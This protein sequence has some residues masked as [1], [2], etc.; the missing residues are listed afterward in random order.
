[1]NKTRVYYQP[2]IYQC[3]G[4]GID[5]VFPDDLLSSFEAFASVEDCEEFME[6]NG[7][8]LCEIN[9]VQYHNDDIEGVT[10]LDAD[11]NVV[12]TNED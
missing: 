9:I 5:W 10:I 7:Y 6:N 12:E 3:D 1:M 11:G 4:A 8:S 2:Y